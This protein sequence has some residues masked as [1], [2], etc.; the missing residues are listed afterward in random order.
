MGVTKEVFDNKVKV[1]VYGTLKKGFPNHW[2]MKD[3]NAKFI[4]ENKSS[5]RKYSLFNYGHIPFLSY[6]HH[7]DETPFKILGEVYEVE[8]RHLASLD[9]FESG[10]TRD[11]IHLE[12]SSMAFVYLCRSRFKSNRIMPDNNK[13]YLEWT[14]RRSE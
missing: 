4:G 2:L 14:V 8:Y 11:I 5:L 13:D 6:A 3:I 12:D 10:Y 1:F 7:P 9:A